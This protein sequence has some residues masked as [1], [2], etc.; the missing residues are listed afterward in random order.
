M[1]QLAQTVEV[2][3]E[4]LITVCTTNNNNKKKLK[5]NKYAE[6][7]LENQKKSVENYKQQLRYIQI[8]QQ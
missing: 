7:I 4:V 5:L 6:K 1:Q 8:L 3:Q 2:M